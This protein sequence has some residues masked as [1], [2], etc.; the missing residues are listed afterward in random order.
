MKNPYFTGPFAPMCELFVAQKR[1]IGKKYE[2]GARRLKQFDSFA[3]DY[4]INDYQMTPELVNAYCKQRTTENANSR[5]ERIYIMWT[6]AEFLAAQGY[7]SSC[8]PSDKP[9]PVAAHT[10]YIFTKEEMSAIFRQLDSM[11]IT[12]FT[13]RHIMFP[14]LFRILYGCGLRISE[15][16]MLKKEDVDIENGIIYV[17]HGKGDKERI[18]VMSDSLCHKCSEF[19]AEA[20][21][22]TDNNVPF[23]YTKQFSKLSTSSVNS[24]FR[25]VLWNMGIPYYGKDV[26]PRVHDLRHTF[27][28]HN[29]QKWAEAGV[30]IYSKLP[31]LAK[32]VGHA[33]T[34]ATQWYI[35][36][37]AESYPHIRH[38]CE[39][40]LGK[41]YDNISVNLEDSYHEQN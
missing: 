25:E 31:V 11:P 8:L 22:E 4:E 13:T 41:I 21:A 16:L 34:N 24:G 35:R 33:S 28:C 14:M 39:N 5:R 2:T 26:G 27:I 18:V 29:I 38:V 10:P 15:V 23:F 40:E 37:T 6:F 20:H 17:Q 32:Y 12:N 36:L 7:P 30:P 19:I 1:A 3:K 9:K